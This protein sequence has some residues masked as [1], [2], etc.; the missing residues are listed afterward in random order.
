MMNVLT[1]YK[2]KEG[3][4][5]R[6][7]SQLISRAYKWVALF[8][9]AILI[10]MAIFAIRLP[11]LL[12]GDGF[13]IDGEHE[14]VM[15]TVS[16]QFDM[17]AETMFVVF[18]HQSNDTIKQT[19]EEIESLQLTSAIDSP[20]EDQ[21]LQKED[22]AYAM[23]HFDHETDHMSQIVTDIRATFD[24]QDGITLTGA[25][26]L[27][28]D[29]NEASQKDLITA[30][31]I[32][33]PV[34]IIILLFAFGT[35]VA[36]LVPLAIGITTVI[37]SFGILTFIGEKIDLSIFVLNIIPMLGLALSIDFALLFISRYREERAHSSIEDAVKMTIQTA[38]RSVIF[39]AF[40]VFIGLGAMLL[41]QIDLFQNI[42]IGGMIVVS[43][44]VLTSITLLPSILLLLGNRIDKWQVLKT[45]K[46]GTN[47]WRQFANSVIKRPVTITLVA[48]I[49]LTIA[50]IP[51]KNM[52]LT[53]PELDALPMS[54]DSRA[55]FELMEDTFDMK[56][57]SSLY[58]IAKR[59][60][61]WE[62]EDGLNALKSLEET[63]E[64]DQLVEE[65]TTIFSASDI[66]SVEEWNGAMS[67]PEIAAS[68]D[69]LVE[70]FIQE[71]EVM[72]PI[73][74]NVEGTSNAAQ[75]WVRDWQKEH[76]DWSVQIGGEPRFNQEIFDEIW[77]KIGLVLTV[78]IASTFIILMI[79]FRSLLIP[80]KAILMNVIGLASTFG[81]LVYIFQYGHF[82]L[83]AGTIALIIPVLVFS[84]VFGLSM[85]YEV[86]LI[87]RMQ[88]E[89]ATSFNNDKA[90]VEGLATTSKVITSAALI[91]IVLTGA[92]AFTDVM[93]VKQIGVGIAIA[94]AIDA[95]II[96][97]LLVP[98]LMK[99]FGKWNWWLP[100]N[101]G[102]YRRDNKRFEQKS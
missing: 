26:P 82:G 84:L 28:K 78:I 32:G 64:Q 99:L 57:T 87:S 8:W 10:A 48:I 27:S 23:L 24:G 58:M 15:D 38:G 36:A 21:S 14:A 76:P 66:Q 94:V 40:C 3:F 1:Y 101:K 95:T 53:I 46:N 51:V 56:D 85:D 41:I 54:Y 22:V 7:F 2:K 80:I 25:S 102:L 16:K 18:D 67:V 71:D 62:N 73:T 75:T 47:R 39:S 17:P 45:K 70:Q 65:V 37:T 89:Y 52:K 5:V 86:F 90:T 97:L 50:M 42:A 33:L 11:N 43:M 12:E 35:V 55:A 9:V 68:L 79:A 81:I 69:P 59:A 20:L 98:S 31:A 92:F 19:L 77:D 91:M 100:F 34:A 44:A 88:E 93:P 60:G 74:L 29:I 30:E 4:H 13:R 49:L 61:G 6:I 83:P 72:I 96:R 63:F